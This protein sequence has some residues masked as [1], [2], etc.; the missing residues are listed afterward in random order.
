MRKIEEIKSYLFKSPDF[1]FIDDET[2]LKRYTTSEWVEYRSWLIKNRLFNIYVIKALYK[3]AKAF[4]EK[5]R[6]SILMPVFNPDPWEIK[7]AID[8]VLWQG[9]PYWELCIV[10]DSSD[11]KEYLKLLH[12][13]KDE[14]IK[15]YMKDYRGGIAETSQYALRVA[16]GDYVVSLDQDDELY[17]DALFSFADMLQKND[18][19]YFYSDRDMISPQ[20][21]RYMHLFKPDWSPEY[22]LSFN[23][24]TH[25]EVYNKHLVLDLGGFRK[26]YEGSQDYDLALRVTEKTNKIQ[27]HPMILYSWR[28]SVNSIAS[29]LEAKSYIY[30][31]GVKAVMD[32]VKR[33]NLPVTEVFENPDLW[34]GHY[35][36]VWD[37]DFFSDKKTW[38]II[39]SK[40]ATETNRIKE[41]FKD[42]I[43]LH[44]IHFLQTNYNIENINALL[45]SIQHEGYVFFCDDSVVGIVSQG[46]TDM[47][48]FLSINGVGAVGCKFLDNDDK[49]FNVGLSF[50]SKGKI[51]F[52]YRGSPR[53]EHGYGAVASVPRNVSAIFPTFWG[54]KISTLKEKGYFQEGQSYFQASVN[55][56]MEILKSDLRIACI[57]YLCLKV[58]TGKIQYVD[59]IHIFVDQ[60]VRN[61]L[62]DR[63]Y[64][65]NLTDIFED[66]GING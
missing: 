25:L 66:F 33:R 35:R 4:K 15:V 55:Y 5:P 10:D 28:Q 43:N 11:N 16:T 37:E 7:Q 3:K 22:L 50:S 2:F 30:D 48:G 60:W 8:S 57:P 9:Y 47:L 51:I 40:N 62:K 29:N 14:R 20:G 23:Y 19:D 46:F 36:I 58:D 18:I 12:R 61:G 49:I 31:T 45:K 17:P 39:I 21:K 24:V 52:N 1:L 59:E 42:I 32:T 56:F 44:N 41:L 6:I 53:S 65:P 34:R 26:E 27:H 13:L 63:Y 38:F 54:C 64:N